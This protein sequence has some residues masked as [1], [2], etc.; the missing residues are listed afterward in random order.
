MEIIRHPY[1][2]KNVGA[3]ERGA[4]IMAGSLLIYHGIRRRSK[5]G[6]AMGLAGVACV[7]R[8]ITGFCYTYQALGFRTAERGQGEHISVPYELGVRVDRAIT[9]NRPRADVYRFWRN[10]DNLPKFMDHLDCVKTVDDR[11]S[12]W[13]AKAPAGRKM[14]WDA[15]IINEVENE[16]IGWRSLPG[17][18]VDNAGSVRFADAGGD[19]GT[20]VRVSLQY[21]PPAGVIGALFAKLFGEEPGQQIENDLRHFKRIL[22]TG[23]LPTSK[24]QSSARTSDQSAH[25]DKKDRQSNDALHASE[26]SF[27]ASD[28]PAY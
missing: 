23:E 11:R 3:I 14:E 8:G 9:V 1:N 28:A 17:A 27:P 26:A 24:G 2:T 4:S 18:D 7:R 5:L 20:E 21:N 6:L 22:E 13:V 12:H 16:L 19:R 10:L 25:A 15:E